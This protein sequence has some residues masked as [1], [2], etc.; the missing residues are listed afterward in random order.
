M[1]RND[2]AEVARG[3]AV[4]P[5]DARRHHQDRAG[6]RRETNAKLLDGLRVVSRVTALCSEL[7]SRPIPNCRGS[8]TCAPRPAWSAAPTPTAAT[9][10]AMIRGDRRYRVTGTRGTTAYL[11]LPGARRHRD[12][13]RAEWPPTSA[14]PTCK[15]DAGVVRPGVRRRRAITRRTR[16]ARN[17]FRSPRTRSSIVVREYVG[18]AAAEEPATL[19]HRGAR[20]RATAGR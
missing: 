10:L 6:R 7:S 19:A 18:D 14:T 5:A 12:D 4:R 20:R 11:G 9:C 16:L 3:L 1:Y 8:S 15:L 2:G 13:A 17:G